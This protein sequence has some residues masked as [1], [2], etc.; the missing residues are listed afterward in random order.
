MTK[1]SI[2][3]VLV[4]SPLE[5]RHRYFIKELLKDRSIEVVSVIVDKSNSKLSIKKYFSFSRLLHTMLS[6]YELS[7]LGPVLSRSIPV[8]KVTSLADKRIISLTNELKP[9]LIIVYGG[10]VIPKSTLDG[11]SSP[12]INI[13]GSI[14]PGYRGLDSYWWALIEKNRHLMGYS[15][16]FVEPGIDTGALI[17]VKPYQ[18][19]GQSI[20]KHFSWRVWIA[21]DSAY[22]ISH[23]LESQLLYSKGV[24]H[25]KAKSKYRSKIRLSDVLSRR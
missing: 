7:T 16:H 25:L 15:I 23:L 4:I 19:S 3:R 6:V 5:L 1:N 11:L 13:H 22:E 20:L 10:K 2:S 14:L 12:C 24:I 8:C 9:K 18:Y 21:E 17:K